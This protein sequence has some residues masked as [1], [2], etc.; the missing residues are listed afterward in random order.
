MKKIIVT[1]LLYCIGT[2]AYSQQKT[3]D[4]LKTLIS[5]TR[6]DSVKVDALIAL[7]REYLADSPSIAI[8][9]ANEAKNLAEKIN[10]ARGLAYA[11]KGLGLVYNF[12]GKYLEAI[13]NYEH[14]LAIFDSIDDKRGLANILNNEGA[15][16][17]S[18]ADYEK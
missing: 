17:F 8:R 2:T 10:Y 15:V 18:Q 12:Q 4:S 6:F 16:F 1:L 13:E 5:L 9:Y 7:N 11:Y 14:S 3:T